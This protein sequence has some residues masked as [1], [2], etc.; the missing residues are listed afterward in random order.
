MS[1]NAT[2]VQQ[3]DNY[4]KDKEPAA[5]VSLAQMFQQRLLTGHTIDPVK[6]DLEILYEQK[7][8]DMAAHPETYKLNDLVTAT[9][10]KV[11][12]QVDAG[13]DLV[14]LL[15]SFDVKPKKMVEVK[16]EGGNDL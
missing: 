6:T 7:V 2:V 3:L 15:N 10:T 1:N 13:E 9:Q 8:M 12:M 4:R 5:V 16:A 14:L 11:N